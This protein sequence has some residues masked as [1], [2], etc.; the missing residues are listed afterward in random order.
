MIQVA[1]IKPSIEIE[2]TP[3]R[4]VVIDI[5]GSPT[6]INPHVRKE[7]ELQVIAQEET[8]EDH[9]IKIAALV[10][11]SCALAEVLLHHVFH[12]SDC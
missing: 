3:R 10:L 8:R 2:H 11:S 6:L 4:S 9:V 1:E 7:I 12:L 5:P